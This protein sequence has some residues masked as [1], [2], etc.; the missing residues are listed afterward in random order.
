MEIVKPGGDIIAVGITGEPVN[1][2]TL[3]IVRSEITIHGTII[4]T[5]DDFRTASEYLQDP[6]FDVSPV[7]SK[8]VPIGQFQRAFDDALSGNYAKIV[9]D[10]K[11]V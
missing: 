3:R 9:L 1:F 2:P 7:V 4:Y 10:F 8:I 5:L 11:E 6:A